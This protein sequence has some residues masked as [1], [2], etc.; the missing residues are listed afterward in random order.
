[1]NQ[2]VT[3]A[4][5]ARILRLDEQTRHKLLS[6]IGH[7]EIQDDDLSRLLDEVE[8][9]ERMERLRAGRRPS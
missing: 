9:H 7:S 4:T 1:M 8:M 2:G 6:N 3:P 5:F